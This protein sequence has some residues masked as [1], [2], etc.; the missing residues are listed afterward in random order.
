MHTHTHTKHGKHTGRLLDMHKCP[1]LV[2]IK[3]RSQAAGRCV[4]QQFE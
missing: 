3:A 2:G 4:C 1:D